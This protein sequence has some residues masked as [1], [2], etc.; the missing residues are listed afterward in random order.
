[1]SGMVAKKALLKSGSWTRL[2][3]HLIIIIIA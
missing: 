1:M 3:H 2:N